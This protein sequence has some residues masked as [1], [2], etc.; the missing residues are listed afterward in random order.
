MDSVIRPSNNRGLEVIAD[1]D[2]SFQH[3]AQQLLEGCHRLIKTSSAYLDIDVYG[4]PKTVSSL[5]KFTRGCSGKRTSHERKT[6]EAPNI[7]RQSACHKDNPSGV[8]HRH[9]QPVSPSRH[10]S[11]RNGETLGT[12]L[13]AVV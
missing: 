10:V 7:W 11:V 4:A 13:G 2:V 5:Y 6:S 1:I 3:P 12:M 9:S 8:S